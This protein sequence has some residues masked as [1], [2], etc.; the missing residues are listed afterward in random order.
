MKMMSRMM[1][2]CKQAGRLVE[3]KLA[4]EISFKERL[5]LVFHIKMCQACRQYEKQSALIQKILDD[6]HKNPINTA[7]DLFKK[8]IK[9]NF[10]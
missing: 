5:Q 7:S 3:R 6:M 2:S 10:K 9:E 8:R 1:I 4:G